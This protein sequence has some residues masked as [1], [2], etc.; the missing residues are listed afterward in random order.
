MTSVLDLTPD[1]LK[2]EF[3]GLGFEPYRADQV[4]QWIY[5]KGVYDFDRMTN[6]SV[7]LREKLKSLFSIGVMAVQLS[8]V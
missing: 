6:L 2:K 4:L 1:E 8:I 3:A 5:G 7:A